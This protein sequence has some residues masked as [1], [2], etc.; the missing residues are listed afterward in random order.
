MHAVTDLA[1]VDVISVKRK[2]S[3]H[4]CMSV[5]QSDALLQVTHMDV[6]EGSCA[7]C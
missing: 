6:A 3:H 7:D 4:I 2:A 1:A 5:A